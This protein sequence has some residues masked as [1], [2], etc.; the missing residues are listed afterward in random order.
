M[1]RDI[2]H[3]NRAHLHSVKNWIA[4]EDYRRSRA[5]YG[6][7]P[8]VLPLLNLPIDEQPTYTDMLV[9]AASLLP[10]GVR[11]LELGVSVGK[12]FYVLANAF[13]DAMLLGFDWEKI[14][15]LLERRFHRVTTDRRLCWYRY[16]T[17]RIGYLQG[18]IA[19]AEDWAALA[20]QKFNLVLSDACHQ[21]RMLRRE[22]AMLER[23]DLLV[24][25]WD[26]LDRLES[27]P[28]TRAF[29]R[30]ADFLQA[31]YRLPAASV[32]RVELNGWLGQHEHKHTVGVINNLGLTASAFS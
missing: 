3:K 5:H 1:N 27:G 30:I 32:F 13:A 6:C 8:R 29:L 4:L 9:Y 14:N 22:L 31:R 11:H 15:P 2:I 28:V 20:G 26:D 24:I 12:N 7:P 16:G 23:Y 21:P 17:N 25:V 10:S 18:D 19:S